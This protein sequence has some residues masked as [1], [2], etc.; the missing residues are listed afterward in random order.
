MLV[1]EEVGLSVHPPTEIGR[2]FV[3]VLGE[4]NRAVAGRADRVLLVVAGRVLDLPPG[5]GLDP[6]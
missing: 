3:D 5:D 6:C 4:L 2:L 1:S